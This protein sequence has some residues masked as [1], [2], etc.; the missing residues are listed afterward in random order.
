MAPSAHRVLAR[1]SDPQKKRSSIDQLEVEQQGRGPTLPTRT[2]QRNT[3]SKRQ[4]PMETAE[5]LSAADLRVL[6]QDQLDTIG[7]AFVPPLPTPTTARAIRAHQTRHGPFFRLFFS[8]PSWTASLLAVPC[9]HSAACMAAGMDDGASLALLLQWSATVRRFSESMSSTLALVQSALD[10]GPALR[11]LTAKTMPWDEVASD[12]RAGR[13]RDHR[14]VVARLGDVAGPLFA[15]ALVHTLGAEELAA[16]E[17]RIAQPSRELLRRAQLQAQQRA[18]EQLQAALDL[19]RWDDDDSEERAILRTCQGTLKKLGRTP[20]Q[21][22]RKKKREMAASSG[23][24]SEEGGNDEEEQQPRRSARRRLDPDS[25]KEAEEPPAEEEE[26]QPM[27]VVE[28]EDDSPTLQDELIQAQWSTAVVL[29]LMAKRNEALALPPLE[30]PNPSQ[31]TAEAGA[32]LAANRARL[33]AALAD[34]VLLSDVEGWGVVLQWWRIVERCYTVRAVLEHLRAQRKEARAAAAKKRRAKV[35]T[36]KEAWSTLLH[37]LRG[38]QM[39]YERAT[40]FDRVGSFLVRFPGFAF[41]THWTS[42]AHWAQ[43]GHWLRD[44]EAAMDADQHAFWSSFEHLRAFHAHLRP[45]AHL[46]NGTVLHFRVE[47]P[48][49][50][51]CSAVGV[52]FDENDTFASLSQRLGFNLCVWQRSGEDG[53]GTTLLPVHVAEYGNEPDVEEVHVLRDG[54]GFSSLSCL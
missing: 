45:S 44:L 28:Q 15:R 2:Q 32:A 18:L 16:L 8:P 37:D 26:E 21:V 12:V 29:D 30:Q 14:S 4:P 5:A 47:G 11:A 10:S 51:L 48:A 31:A 3:N 23:G 9:L 41:Q 33:R 39:C 36:L 1:S 24:D 34:D 46:A 38:C 54:G 53:Y 42:F 52:A 17:Q 6:A 19:H 25:Y 20:L 13:V 27:E 22:A 50:D 40:L 43:P 7:L 49:V 35:P